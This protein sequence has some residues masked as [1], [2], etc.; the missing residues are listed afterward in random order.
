[1][2][3]EILL[4]EVITML[5]IDRCIRGFLSVE[6]YSREKTLQVQRHREMKQHGVSGK[7]QAD[8][9]GWNFEV[10]GEERLGAEWSR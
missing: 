8:W 9:T 6:Q 5:N 10:Q 3:M 7:L 2:V 4:E 1:M